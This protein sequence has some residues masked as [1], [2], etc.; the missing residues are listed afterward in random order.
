MKFRRITENSMNQEQ[1]DQELRSRLNLET[2]RLPWKELLRH[3]AGGNVIGISSDLDLIEVALRIARDDT[4]AVRGWMETERLAKV[5]DEQA[6]AWLEE[7]AELWA[8]VVKPWV[9][10]QRHRGA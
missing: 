7:D 5:S 8:V 6:A 9:L 2:S 1:K 3:Y 10:V 4:A